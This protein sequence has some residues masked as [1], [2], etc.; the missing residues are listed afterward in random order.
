MENV[1]MESLWSWTGVFWASM[2]KAPA[3]ARPPAAPLPISMAFQRFSRRSGSGAIP[4][5]EINQDLPKAGAWVQI[6]R[7]SSRQSRI[8]ASFSRRYSNV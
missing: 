8:F 4:Y 1:G 3:A 7:T 6:E 5:F 2:A